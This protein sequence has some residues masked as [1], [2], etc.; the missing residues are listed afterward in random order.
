VACDGVST[1]AISLLCDCELNALALWKRDPRLLRSDDKNVVLTSSERVVYGILDVD[2]VETS[3]MTLA[4]GDDT[5]ATHVTTSSDHS[6]NT[7]IKLDKISDLAGSKV[8]L[9][10]IIDLDCWI[11][12]T[13]TTTSLCQQ[14]N[15]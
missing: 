7:S 6:N 9:H 5:Y 3:I 14:L 15:G 13:D 8:N 11:W 1:S 10:G 4:V 12:I 2:N